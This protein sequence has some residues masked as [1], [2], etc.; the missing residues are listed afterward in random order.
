M[1]MDT[2]T[3]LNPEEVKKLSPQNLKELLD[4]NLSELNTI[5]E[6][7]T[8]QAWIKAHTQSEVNA[9]GL[10]IMAGHPDP[11]PDGFF[12]LTSAPPISRAEGALLKE[13]ISQISYTTLLTLCGVMISLGAS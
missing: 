1:D 12:V 8:V 3:T 9:I 2:F 7:S 11:T 13:H 4:T 10:K 5:V 6:H